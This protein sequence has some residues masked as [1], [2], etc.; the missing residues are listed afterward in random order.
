MTPR[1]KSKAKTRNPCGMQGS[2]GPQSTVI[3]VGLARVEDVRSNP[4]LQWDR[5]VEQQ[6]AWLTCSHQS[7]AVTVERC[8]FSTM[9]FA[10]HAR[11]RWYCV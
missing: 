7:D 3:T 2:S 4:S 11:S 6:S 9:Q 10:P 1:S 5:I 8:D